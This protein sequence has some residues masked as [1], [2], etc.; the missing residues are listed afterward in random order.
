[1]PFRLEVESGRRHD[2]AD[3][4]LP[5]QETLIGLVERLA[6]E[7]PH[8]AVHTLLALKNS[9]RGRDG[10]V[11][12]SGASSDALQYNVDLDKVAA[13]QDVLRRTSAHPG[14]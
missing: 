14:L 5:V 8:H 13:A 11:G 10:K 2:A 1:M 9:A 4:D 6:R 7:H 3:V 12:N